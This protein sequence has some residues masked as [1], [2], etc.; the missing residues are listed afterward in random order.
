MSE[1]VMSHEPV[2]GEGVVEVT[3]VLD[4]SEAKTQPLGEPLAEAAVEQPQATLYEQA[5]WDQDDA[6]LAEE[7]EPFADTPLN[8]MDHA[9]LVE[10]MSFV[11]STAVENRKRTRELA[12]KVGTMAVAPK[13]ACKRTPKAPKPAVEAVEAVDERVAVES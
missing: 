4:I 8:R 12:L 10:F 9:Q 11:W 13:P 7:F 5:F 6:R 1:V 2:V 3:E